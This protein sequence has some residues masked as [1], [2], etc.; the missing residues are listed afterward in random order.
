MSLSEPIVPKRGM[1]FLHSH[2]IV[3]TL[4][5]PVRERP[6]ETCEVTRVTAFS[7]CYRNSTGFKMVTSREEFPE[8]VREILP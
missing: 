3:N 7:V 5:V 2:Q 4:G 8:S 6:P 1:R